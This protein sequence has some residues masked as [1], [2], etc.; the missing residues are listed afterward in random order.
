MV[1]RPDGTAAIVGRFRQPD[2]IVFDIPPGK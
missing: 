1:A 2:L